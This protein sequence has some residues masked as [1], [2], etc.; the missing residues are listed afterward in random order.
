ME[1]VVYMS[2]VGVIKEDKKRK[3]IEEKLEV[4]YDD[5]DLTVVIAPE[6]D[7]LKQVILDLLKEKPMD[8]KEIHSILTNLASDEKI[9]KALYELAEEGK[10]VED[11]KTRKFMI[12]GIS[13]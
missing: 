3:E 11:K 4:V 2:S 6:E 9:R 7:E 5:D 10:V 12:V 1:G 8:V 13:N